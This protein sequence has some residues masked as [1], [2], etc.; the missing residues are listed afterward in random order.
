MSPLVGMNLPIF[1]RERRYKTVTADVS[2]EPVIL[3]IQDNGNDLEEEGGDDFVV[4]DD[5]LL[6][7]LDLSG[8]LRRLNLLRQLLRRLLRQR[9]RRLLRQS[10]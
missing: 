2:P 8:L 10:L 1:V 9:L 3:Q 7:E 4:I 5:M 6:D